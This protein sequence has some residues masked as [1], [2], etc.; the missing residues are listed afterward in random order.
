MIIAALYFLVLLGAAII[1]GV[2]WLAYQGL[3]Y[4][5]QQTFQPEEKNR[6]NEVKEV[7]RTI[8]KGLTYLWTDD[9]GHVR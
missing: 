7:F 6:R 2:F 3:V 9:V 4:L 5:W 8:R 1:L